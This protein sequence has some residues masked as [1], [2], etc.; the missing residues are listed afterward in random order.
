MK[1]YRN[2]P[3]I[4]SKEKRGR[5]ITLAGLAILFL[6]LL[7]SFIPNWYP[8]GPEG[9]TEGGFIGFLQMFWPYISF[10]ALALG[11]IASNIGSYY[12]NRFAPRRWPGTRQ[13]ARPD[14]LV[15]R[16]LKGFDN[17]Y[18][19]FLWSLPQTNYLLV[20]PPG[21]FVFNVKGDKGKV[22]VEGDR[23]KE[24]FSIGRLF[25]SF[26][27]EGLGNPSRELE[28]DKQKIRELLQQGEAA[29]K[30]SLDAAEVPIQGA[31]VFINPGVTLNA[32]N[33]SV[34]V[35]QTGD[36]KKVIRDNKGRMLNTTQ[37][38][39]LTEFLKA[40]SAVGTIETDLREGV[41]E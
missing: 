36:I 12:I 33:P 16:S 31:V 2:L 40:Q 13:I 30:H 15:E 32:V 11:F 14:E 8:I 28:E 5:Q 21:I 37:V 17:K 20:G 27:R 7:S 29:D 4:R 22:T 35:V 39:E 23:W 41:K 9:E 24:A 26:T 18:S 3:V 1:V 19:L 38:R 10:G 34:P 6:G 25:T